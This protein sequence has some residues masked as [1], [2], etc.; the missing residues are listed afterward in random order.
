MNLI[1]IF[2][3]WSLDYL[4]V[5]K[6]QVLG[7]FGSDKPEAYRTKGTSPIL[8]I[9]GVYENWRFVR[10]LAK[11]LKSSGYD[12]HVLDA[13]GYNRGT[14]EEMAKLVHEYIDKNNLH[15]VA[16]VAHSKGG[17]IGKYLLAQIQDRNVLKGMV[18]INTPFSGSKYAYAFPLRSIRVFTP[19]SKILTLLTKDHDSNTSIVSLYGQF[20]PHIPGGSYLEG[21]K[22]I[23][24]QT[25]GHFRVI[26]DPDVQK[27]VLVQVAR[28][29]A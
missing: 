11:I 10:P 20:D 25:Y 17:L 2:F 24:L 8:L 14:I 5:F 23:K 15:G 26:N 12:I 28:L 3:Y 18:A 19:T 22:N 21:A 27:A 6:A 7:F 16:V 29:L 9:P 4:Y 1:K 13:L